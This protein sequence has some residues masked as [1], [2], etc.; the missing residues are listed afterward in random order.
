MW[1]AVR[2][3]G[4]LPLGAAT[5]IGVVAATLHLARPTF[6]AI[7]D[8]LNGVTIWPW[9]KFLDQLPRGIAAGLSWAADRMAHDRT[10]VVVVG[11]L[12]ILVIVL[13][14]IRSVEA[15]GPPDGSS[16][17][18][19]AFSLA[20]FG[21]LLLAAAVGVLALPPLLPLAVVTL[22]TRVVLVLLDYGGFVLDWL[23]VKLGL[24]NDEDKAAPPKAPRLPGL[25]AK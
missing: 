14:G 21:G 24:A 7:A 25:P 1:S 17:G 15:D 9:L 6:V 13:A 5:V 11:G 20:G 19:A 16:Q 22:V 18:P 3:F 12:A 10:Y 23:R 2:L 4:F 8:A